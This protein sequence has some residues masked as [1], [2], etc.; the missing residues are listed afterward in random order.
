MRI[1]FSSHLLHRLFIKLKLMCVSKSIRRYSV[2]PVYKQHIFPVNNNK[3]HSVSENGAIN[4]PVQSCRHTQRV[5]FLVLHIE[6]CETFTS[7]S[8]KFRVST[9]FDTFKL[10]QSIHTILDG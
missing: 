9:I 5:K 2:H 6:C 1:D 8:V 7:T 10:L 4:N 3:R